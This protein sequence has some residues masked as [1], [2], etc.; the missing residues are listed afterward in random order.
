MATRS[1]GPRPV[2]SS[3]DDAVKRVLKQIVH[4]AGWFNVLELD[5]P[6]STAEEAVEDLLR[7]RVKPYES[8][9][10]SKRYCLKGGDLSLKDADQVAREL[11]A[12]DLIQQWK[13]FSREDWDPEMRVSISLSS[14]GRT[15]T[16]GV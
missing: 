16:V 6:G 5:N 11:L 13:V 12:N 8:V 14:M 2:P 15:V 3:D 9:Y 7:I 10:T 1:C 4:W